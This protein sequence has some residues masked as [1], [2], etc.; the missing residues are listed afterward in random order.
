MRRARC[1]S[2]S[3]AGVSLVLILRRSDSRMKRSSLTMGFVALGLALG[4]S[5]TWLAP[6]HAQPTQAPPKAAAASG[7]FAKLAEAVK[8]A[9]INVSSESKVSGSRTPHEERDGEDYFKRF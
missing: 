3:A 2:Y 1:A 6:G 9:V 7:S 5:T 4:L 8:P